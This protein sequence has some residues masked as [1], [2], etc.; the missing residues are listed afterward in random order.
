MVHKLYTK[1]KSWANPTSN[2]NSGKH[3]F[4][5]WKWG[6]QEHYYISMDKSNFMNLCIHKINLGCSDIDWNL[7]CFQKIMHQDKPIASGHL[8][9]HVLIPSLPLQQ[10]ESLSKENIQTAVGD[11][12]FW[13]LSPTGPHN[14]VATPTSSQFVV[15]FKILMQIQLPLHCNDNVAIG[16]CF[17]SPCLCCL[18]PNG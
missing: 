4:K 18:C 5:Q 11:T 12:C 10:K 6:L 8:S 16:H 13:L 3:S 1:T 2:H 7:S 17:V 9:H 14:D 15:I